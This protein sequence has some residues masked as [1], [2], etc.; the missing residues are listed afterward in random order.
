MFSQ[1]V[2]GD[3]SAESIQLV[4]L[5]DI[6]AV[7]KILEARVAEILPV[8]S[9][10]LK[11]PP[12]TGHQRCVRVESCCFLEPGMLLRDRPVA[13]RSFVGD[14]GISLIVFSTGE[15]V[16]LVALKKYYR[17]TGGEECSVRTR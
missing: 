9:H 15:F 16:K 11:A 5:A 10:H 7:D 13:A 4:A 3:K 6:H 2:L 12:G 1:P 17:V 8:K 14:A